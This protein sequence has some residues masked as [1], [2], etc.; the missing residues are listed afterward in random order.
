MRSARGPSLSPEVANGSECHV[1][2]G[3]RVPPPPEPDMGTSA[4]LYVPGWHKLLNL[5]YR[6]FAFIIH[7][8]LS[9]HVKLWTRLILGDSGMD[10]H[11]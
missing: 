10:L 8:C 3:T 1:I 9:A 11:I 6:R 5:K 7:Y 2:W 4:A